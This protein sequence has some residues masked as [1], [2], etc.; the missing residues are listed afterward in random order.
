MTNHEDMQK[1]YKPSSQIWLGFSKKLYG[2]LF[3]VLL[4]PNSL[5]VCLKREKQHV[6]QV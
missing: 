1:K 2:F 6:E 4:Y 5:K 3:S